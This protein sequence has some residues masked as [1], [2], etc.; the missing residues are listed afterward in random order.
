M[1]ISVCRIQCPWKQNHLL[2]YTVCATPLFG[3]PSLFCKTLE[4]KLPRNRALLFSFIP[5]SMKY[6][7]L[8]FK[9]EQLCQYV[10]SI[11][12]KLFLESMANKL[13]PY[14][15]I[16]R[17]SCYAVAF[18]FKRPCCPITLATVVVPRLA[19]IDVPLL[20][21]SVVLD[22]QPRDS[23]PAY[24]TCAS[25]SFLFS[26]ADTNKRAS[27]GVLLNDT[28]ILITV[29]FCEDDAGKG[30]CF[31][32]PAGLK[33]N[34]YAPSLE[35]PLYSELKYFCKKI[36]EAYTELKEDLTPFRDDRFYR[37][38][39]SNFNVSMCGSLLLLMMMM[40]EKTELCP[41]NHLT[42]LKIK[43]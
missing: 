19:L 41:A 9:D 31:R 17:I 4:D 25:A 6:Y 32:P 21:L 30:L 36:Q 26:W 1:C 11:K 38:V 29:L 40:L 18:H 42:Y 10:Y 14:N 8:G 34:D 23:A 7:V 16:N 37:W 43:I 33:M 5:W 12:N 22:P 20:T 13:L 27:A 35:N 24:Q 28:I 39:R 3:K 2:A 15:K